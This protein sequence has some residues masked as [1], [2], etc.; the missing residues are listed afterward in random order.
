MAEE[1]FDD[2][3]SVNEFIVPSDTESKNVDCSQEARSK[4]EETAKILRL[5]LKPY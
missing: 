5:R 2:A 4:S 3:M 1:T